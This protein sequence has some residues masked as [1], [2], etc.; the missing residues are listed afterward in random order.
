VDPVL[1]SSVIGHVIVQA[2][3]YA[4]IS[5]HCRR[6]HLSNSLG[7]TTWAHP[8]AWEIVASGTG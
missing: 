1:N 3:G 7:H 5:S 2:A 8:V 6:A 4:M